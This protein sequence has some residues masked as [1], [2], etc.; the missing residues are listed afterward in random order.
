MSLVWSSNTM[1]IANLEQSSDAK[2]KGLYE[3][4]SCH[5]K[6]VCVVTLFNEST[7]MVGTFFI[8]KVK[9]LSIDHLD[10]LK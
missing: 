6:S 9:N 8:E 3:T 5:S 2:L 7:Q 4:A 1:Q 10:E